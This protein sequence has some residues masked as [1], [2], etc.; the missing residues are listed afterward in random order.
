M[1]ILRGEPV[2]TSHYCDGKWRAGPVAEC[3]RHRRLDRK[4]TTVYDRSD[5]SAPPSTSGSSGSTDTG[6]GS[7]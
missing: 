4:Q 1:L 3:R 5:E 7:E 6:S 2:A